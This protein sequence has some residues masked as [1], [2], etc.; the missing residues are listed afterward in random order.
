MPSSIPEFA[1]I[2]GSFL[3]WQGAPF[4][5]KQGDVQV[6]AVERA[7]SSDRI[8]PILQ[9]PHRVRRTAE[10]IPE[11]RQR[12]GLRVI[13]ELLVVALVAGQP[14]LAGG[15]ADAEA[16]ENVVDR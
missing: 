6:D 2:G 14:L 7:Q 9:H 5:A 1:G 10:R 11:L 12:S 8:G 16:V 15:R 13:L 4:F 3:D